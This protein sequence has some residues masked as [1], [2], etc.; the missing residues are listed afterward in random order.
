MSD[1]SS[2]RTL[3]R[4]AVRAIDRYA[5]ETIGLPGAVLM[6]NAGRGAADIAEQM[7]RSMVSASGRPGT[8]AVVAGAGNNGG[9]GF[10]V[11]RH[12][13]LRGLG[14]RTYLVAPE[15]KL[16]GDAARNWRVLCALEADVAIVGPDALEFLADSLRSCSLVVD[17]V[18]GTG[19]QGALRGDIAIAVEQINAAGRPVL[20]IDIPTGLDCDTGMA[21]GPAVRA[22]A[23]VTFVAVKQGF[24]APGAQAYLG[25]IHVRDIGIPAE[26]VA[27]M[28]GIGR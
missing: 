28:A 9:D 20:A 4:E 24:A 27:R 8:V 16:S 18:G 5:I 23:T 14:V 17:A 3:S 19:I 2:F 12:L 21:G 15:G 6:E 25:K 10:V 22:A 13:A 11:A 1:A 26:A 7:L